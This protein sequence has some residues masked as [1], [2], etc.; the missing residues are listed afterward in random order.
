MRSVIRKWPAMTIAAVLATSLA[1]CSSDDGDGGSTVKEDKDVTFTGDPVKVMTIAPVDTAAI[2]T[3][4]I[5]TAAE[6]ATITINNDGGINGHKVEL[7]SCNDGN[8][9]NTAAECA[10][11]AV[12]EGV[13][14]VVGGFTTNGT[15][16]VPILEEAGVPFLGA[17]AFSAEELSSKVSFP[18]VSGAPAFAKI[19]ARTA[20]DGCESTSIVLYDVPTALKAVDLINLGITSAGGEKGTHI[21]VPT[22]TTNFSAVAK[23]AGEADCSI[24]GLPN[25]QI[26]ALAAAGK[27]QG[28]DTRYY[29]VQGALNQKVIEDSNGAMEGAVSAVNFVPASDPAWED[30]KAASSEIDWTYPYVQNTW[31]S[32][33]VLLQVAGD[34][35]EITAA[36]VSG[37]LSKASGVD[38]GGLMAPVDFTKEFPVPGLNRVFNTN[39]QFVQAK[40][41]DVEGVSEFEDITPLFGG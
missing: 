28:E 36:T 2:N 12:D 13:V 7:I 19:G 23:S 26:A 30:A 41:S 11:Q 29:A 27:A 21:K 16:I 17:T 15:S 5:V 20:Q 9:P 39:I 22:T 10:R 37:A 35:D 18:L 32:Y 40:G 4:E 14:A 33:Q 38:A 8:D 31:A 1:A 24:L 6:A 25:D 3:P 34:L